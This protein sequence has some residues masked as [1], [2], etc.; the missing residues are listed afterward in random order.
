MD[1]NDGQDDVKDEETAWKTNGQRCQKPRSAIVWHKRT[2]INVDD[3]AKSNET[4]RWWG[5]NRQ[6]RRQR[7]HETSL[8]FAVAADLV[9]VYFCC[10]CHS[11]LPSILALVALNGWEKMGKTLIIC[12]W[13]QICRP[14]RGLS[15]KMA[16]VE[17]LAV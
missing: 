1:H 16:E 17:P 8:L 13:Y 12:L 4:E 9:Y 3:M 5:K 15:A 10:L 6:R 11:D 14:C 2:D 7:K